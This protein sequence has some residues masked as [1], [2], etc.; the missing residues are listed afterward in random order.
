LSAKWRRSRKNSK[1]FKIF[2]AFRGVRNK[3]APPNTRVNDSKVRKRVYANRYRMPKAYSERRA[4]EPEPLLDVIEEKGEIVVV[5][6]FAGFNMESLKINVE[7]QRLTLCA[8]ALDRKYYKSL[9]L[10]KRVIPSTIRTTC[11][12]GVLEI[13][14]KKAIQEKTIDKVAG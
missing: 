3:R 12:N 5:A 1:W 6:E 8:E 10:P 9:N 11:K 7:D 2:K 4:R 14:L 13:Q